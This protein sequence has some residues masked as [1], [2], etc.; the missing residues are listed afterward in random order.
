MNFERQAS[1]KQ[2]NNA[3]IT[4]IDRMGLWTKRRNANH[5]ATELIN[6]RWLS[7]WDIDNRCFLCYL[8][9]YPLLEATV[10]NT[11][12]VIIGIEKKQSYLTTML[13]TDKRTAFL[14]VT[15]NSRNK[16]FSETN[17]QTQTPYLVQKVVRNTPLG[18]KCSDEKLQP[19][20][21]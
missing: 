8:F 1:S 16:A 3:R 4:Q 2:F 17:T 19:T 11:A 12:K 13:T 6:Q 18:F 15:T 20:T 10:S 5:F 14:S 21:T 7:I 9:V